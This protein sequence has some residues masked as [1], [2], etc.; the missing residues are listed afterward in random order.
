[1]AVEVHEQRRVRVPEALGG[2]SRWHAVGEHERCAGVPE[3]VS[4]EAR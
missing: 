4:R 1:M 2:D 3:A